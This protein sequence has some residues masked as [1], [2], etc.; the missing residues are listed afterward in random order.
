[1][2]ES[3]PKLVEHDCTSIIIFNYYLLCRFINTKTVVEVRIKMTRKRKR[4]RIVDDAVN[5]VLVHQEKKYIKLVWQI[6]VF[7]RYLQ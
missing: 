5:R 4:R 7:W 6:G 3:S 2:R 1:M